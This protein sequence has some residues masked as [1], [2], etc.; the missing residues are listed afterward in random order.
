MESYENYDRL[1][2]AEIVKEVVDGKT[3]ET[4]E[5]SKNI[6]I[7]EAS[8]G[9]ESEAYSKGHVPTSVQ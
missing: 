8:W 6:K 5:G 3:P 9:E 7:I 1:V 2:P 4:F